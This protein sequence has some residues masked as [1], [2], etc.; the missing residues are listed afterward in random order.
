ML[1]KVVLALSLVLTFGPSSVPFA[2][3]V[4]Q[5]AKVYRVGVLEQGSP[6]LANRPS[7]FR[8]TLQDL[9]YVEGRNVVLDRRWAEG[10]NERFP[11][12][13]TELVA[14]KPD[15]IVADST[16]AALAA[17]RA[18]TAI[19]I[20]M[21][22]VSDP[23]GTGLVASLARPGGNVTGVTDFGSDLAVKY[24]DFLHNLVPKTYRI[25]VL[26]S[27]NPVHSLQLKFIEDAAQSI[28][29]TVLPTMIKKEADFEQAY[30]SMVSQKAGALI[31]L[32]GAPVSTPAQQNKIIALSASSK[33]PTL[34]PSRGFV[35]KG[36][37]LS[38]AP[39]EAQLSATAAIYVDKIFKGA[40]PA[41]LPVEQ[42]TKVELV[43]NLKTAKAP[44]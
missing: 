7:P 2:A 41:D 4:R 24:V 12:L 26:M 19:P 22:N 44:A 37:L 38:Y 27:D 20:V 28:G 43:I 16:P 1:R 10:E 32:G 8:R 34:F 15:V 29:L 35:E 23:V 6:P 9:G 21:V 3:D 25:A 17:K 11:R 30:A 36:G 5:P 31:W 42:P 18:T 33:L 14:L 13:A 39:N 40:K